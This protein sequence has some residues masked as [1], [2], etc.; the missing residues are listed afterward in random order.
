MDLE[1]T[2]RSPTTTFRV[3]HEDHVTILWTISFGPV[4][5]VHI[6]YRR[7]KMRWYQE[8]SN[9]TKPVILLRSAVG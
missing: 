7:Q 4:S 1:N 8:P 9:V 5:V 2:Q 3:K 6:K